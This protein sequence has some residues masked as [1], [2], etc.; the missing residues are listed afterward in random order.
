MSL[1]VV[2]VSEQGHAS[3]QGPKAWQANLK[4]RDTLERKYPL[5]LVASRI[6]LL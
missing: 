2:S 1:E 6:V 5:T 4:D 3:K